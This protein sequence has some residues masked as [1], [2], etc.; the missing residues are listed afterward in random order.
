[1]KEAIVSYNAPST[2]ME[3][4]VCIQT[5][6]YTHLYRCFQYINKHTY[7]HASVCTY[8]KFK[9]YS[10]VKTYSVVTHRKLLLTQFGKEKQF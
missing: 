7:A 4:N 1:M 6:I 10:V 2:L 5:F 3:Y 9:A 8:V